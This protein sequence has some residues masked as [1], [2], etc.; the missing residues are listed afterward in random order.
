VGYS[1]EHHTV[2]YFMVLMGLVAAAVVA[3]VLCG[4]AGL[5]GFLPSVGRPLASAMIMTPVTGGLCLAC[6]PNPCAKSE[7]LK[8]MP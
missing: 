7:K 8:A 1:R 4:A 5:M 3:S 6:A 2:D